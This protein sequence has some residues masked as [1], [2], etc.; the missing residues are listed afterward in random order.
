MIRV[1]FSDGTALNVEVA[2][3]TAL[4]SVPATKAGR[5]NLPID[6]FNFNFV[7]TPEFFP[8]YMT[9]FNRIAIATAN[10]DA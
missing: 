8:M 5:V 10:L 6:G 3:H 2:M 4:K 1:G 9:K 7:L